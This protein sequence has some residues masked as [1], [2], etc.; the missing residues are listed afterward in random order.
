MNEREFTIKII[1]GKPVFS[2]EALEFFLSSN[3]KSFKAKIHPDLREICKKEKIS[4]KLV[5]KIANTQK[6]PLEIAF[7]VVIS[8]GKIR[9]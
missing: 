9:K 2:D 8:K 5:E 6:I 4:L 3:F 1:N 7:G